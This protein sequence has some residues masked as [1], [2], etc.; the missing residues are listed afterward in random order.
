MPRLPHYPRHQQQ[1]PPPIRRRRRPRLRATARRLV[2]IDHALLVTMGAL[3]M[4][5]TLSLAVGVS[6]GQLGHDQRQFTAYDCTSP[7]ELRA[8]TKADPPQCQDRLDQDPISQKNKTY[9]LLQ[10]AT[11]RR[12]LVSR[13]KVLR[14]RVAHHCGDSD[15]QTFIPQLST[16]RE[17]VTILATK[18]Q[19]MYHQEVWKDHWHHETPI[20]KG[21]TTVIRKELV[22]STN[23]NGEGDTQCVGAV[24][25]QKGIDIPDIMLWEELSI[26]L[27]T[28]ELL[29]DTTGACIVNND[30]IKIGCRDTDLSC[31]YSG[32]TL[33]WTAPTDLEKCCF[34]KICHSTGIV[35]TGSNGTETFISRDGSRIWLILRRPAQLCGEATGFRTN[36]KNLYLM[37]EIYAD[38]VS[39]S[40]LLGE[41]STITYAN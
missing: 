6:K 27:D 2:T 20:A 30:Q 11:Y 29:V 23:R 17:E 35:V 37:D 7:Q 26:T 15:H 10:K 13:C 40:L 28:D 39:A 8:V 31:I 4:V 36:Y 3:L 34:Q 33:F 16:F 5:L 24:Y 41:L 12:H 19:G 1:A 38:Q 22:G 25:R 14:T 18:C 32:G 9:L 21:K